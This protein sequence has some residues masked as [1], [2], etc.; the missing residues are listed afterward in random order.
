MIVREE[1]FDFE[2]F[3][4]PHSDRREAFRTK[5]GILVFGSLVFG[6]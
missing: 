3:G 6:L 5:T 4:D 1:R 2:P